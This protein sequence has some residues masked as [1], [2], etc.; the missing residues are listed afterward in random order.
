ME[1][2]KMR[3]LVAA[4]A[5]VMAASS[6]QKVTAADAPS[7]TLDAVAFSPV[8]FASFAAT[9]FGLLFRTKG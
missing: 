1:A 5:M 6:I 4:I 9:D 2:I 3:V 7:P 8:V